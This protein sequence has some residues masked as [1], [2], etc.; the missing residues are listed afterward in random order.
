MP[1]SL[2]LDSTTIVGSRRRRGLC[3]KD[4]P[5]R[6]TLYYMKC[7]GG[8]MIVKLKDDHV[9]R[10]IR[11]GMITQDGIFQGCGSD[12]PYDSWCLNYMYVKKEKSMKPFPSMTPNEYKLLVEMFR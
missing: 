6:N 9:Q 10:R 1:P 3:K 11:V 7:Y 2:E 4:T 5:P 8:T 12:N